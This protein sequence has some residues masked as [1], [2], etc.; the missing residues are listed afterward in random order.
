MTVLT[1]VTWKR[2]PQGDR[3]ISQRSHQDKTTDHIKKEGNMKKV[4]SGAKMTDIMKVISGQ[5]A[6]YMERVILG[7]D[8]W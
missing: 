7:G 5:N 4:T 2:S 1:K 6:G 8:D 3:L